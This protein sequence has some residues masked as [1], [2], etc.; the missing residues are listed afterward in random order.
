MFEYYIIIFIGAMFSGLSNRRSGLLYFYIIFFFIFFIAFIGLRYEIGAD[1]FNYLDYFEL[2]NKGGWF[3]SLVIGDPGYVLINRLANE[4]GGGVYLVNTIGAAIL[5]YAVI[6]FARSLSL[7]GLVMFISIP[8]LLIVVGMGYTRQSIAVGFE[9]IALSFAL[10]SRYKWAFFYI[11]VATLFHKSAIILFPIF[12]MGF[13]LLG[14]GAVSLFVVISCSLYIILEEQFTQLFNLYVEEQLGS[15][16]AFIRTL[17]NAMPAI[18]FF[19]ERKFAKDINYKFWRLLSS[20]SLVSLLLVGL[21]PV[22][23]DRVV[24]YLFPLQMYVWVNYVG[25]IS[26]NTRQLIYLILIGI[27]SLALIVWLNFGIHSVTWVPYR[28]YLFNG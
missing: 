4:L 1:W 7:P 2:S 25:F 20:I 8:Y 21:Y 10:D 26:G 27:Y 17:F 15:S 16:G 6:R 19:L 11:S 9:I 14:M 5:I 24:I 3:E 22:A 13:N 12:I 23:V 28:S 18:L